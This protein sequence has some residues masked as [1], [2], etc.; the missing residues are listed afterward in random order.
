MQIVVLIM[1]KPDKP[2]SWY[3]GFSQGILT[4]SFQILWDNVVWA[5]KGALMFTCVF[6]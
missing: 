4:I 3:A 2:T 6:P 5:H 1:K